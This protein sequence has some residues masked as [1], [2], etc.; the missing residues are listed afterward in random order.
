MPATPAQVANDLFAQAR[1]F[2]KRDDAV[3]RLCTVAA[4]LIRAKAAGDPYDDRAYQDL[5]VALI[6]HVAAS[7]GVPERET[8]ITKSLRRAL[9]TLQTLR[10]E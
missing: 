3:A 10:A 8:Q 6:K 9:D 7:K 2:A 4:R 5:E 1:Y